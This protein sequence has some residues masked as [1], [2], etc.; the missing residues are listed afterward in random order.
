[1]A[2]FFCDKVLREHD[3]VLSA[4]RIV[5]IVK[6]A[7][8]P[9]G[10][11]QNSKPLLPTV[12]FLGVKSGA[13]KG[14][15]TLKLRAVRPNG[16]ASE[17]LSMPLTLTGDNAGQNYILNVAIGVEEEGLHWFEVLFED[18]VITAVP[19]TI[20]SHI[21]GQEP[22]KAQTAEEGVPNKTPQPE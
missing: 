16:V 22:L 10:L 17:L 4:V 6:F 5:D 18:E 13:L 11:P 7:L 21:L 20:E 12:L 3:E 15:F 2:A 8:P 9:E 14:D 19:L 1:M